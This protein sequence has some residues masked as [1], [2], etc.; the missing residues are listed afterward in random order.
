MK[1]SADSVEVIWVSNM[2]TVETYKSRNN[3]SPYLRGALDT[4]I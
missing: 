4:A 3:P 2:T 1:D